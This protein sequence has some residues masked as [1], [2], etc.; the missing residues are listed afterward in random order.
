[1]EAERACVALIGA[2]CLAPV[3]AHHDGRTLSALLANENARGIKRRGGEGPA[4]LAEDLPPAA[5]ALRG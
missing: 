5:A 2:G 1:M 4:V 3:A